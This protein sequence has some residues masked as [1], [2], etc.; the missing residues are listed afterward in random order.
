MTRK[1]FRTAA[2]LLAL[3]LLLAGCGGGKDGQ[4]APGADNT[5]ELVGADTTGTEITETDT[6]DTTDPTTIET[7]KTED[8]TMD[9]F[10]FGQ[11]SEALVILPGLSVQSVMG[12]AA[13]VEEA[14]QPLAK[15]FTVYV[16]DRRS[17][18]PDTYVIRDMARDT[19]AA[20]RALGLERVSLFGAS[21][22]GMIAM[23][24][25]IDEPDL[26]QKLVLGSTSAYITDTLAATGAQWI[27]LAKA[28]DAAGLYLAFGEAVY[29][30]EVFDP[31]KDLL[32]DLAKTVTAEELERF[33]VLAGGLQGFD[34][35]ADLHR[36]QCPVLLLNATDDRVLGP[37]ATK[38][39]SGQLGNRSD[40]EL[41]LYDGYG[42]AAYDLAPGYKERMLEFLRKD[43][44]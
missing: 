24:I 15:D 14:Y 17:D 43:T 8:F 38:A 33:I 29:P 21:Q 36:I 31:S 16:F 18:L 40:F 37:D 42:H 44:L 41:E 34:V 35:R 39:I 3:L 11:G 27:D 1:H 25:A 7:I 23:Q 9:Y 6:L 26:V 5:Q 12:S 22:G 30:Q 32:L 19:A 10:K 4:P 2:L 28:G 20:I 13:L